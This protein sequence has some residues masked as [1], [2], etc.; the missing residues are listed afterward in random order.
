MRP[1]APFASY[2]NSTVSFRGLSL[3]LSRHGPTLLF[4]AALGVGVLLR[5]IG[6]ADRDLSH[7]EAFTHFFATMPLGELWRDVPK[8]DVHPPLFYALENLIGAESEWRLR[9]PAIIAGALTIPVVFAAGRIA[10]GPKAGAFVGA[11]AAL[12][13]ALSARQ[14]EYAQSARAYAIF[15]LA[16]AVCL[17]GVLL[18]VARRE[19]EE[20]APMNSGDIAGAT[21]VAVGGG[22]M[23]WTHNIAIVYAASIGA[24]GLA[25][26]ATIGGRSLKLL[27]I[28]A[29]AG[30]GA[31]VIWSPAIQYLI[32]QIN[33]VSANYWISRPEPSMIVKIYC[34]TFGL[35][36]GEN[37]PTIEAAVKLVANAALFALGG[38]GLYSMW[39]DGRRAAAVALAFAAFLPAILL[40]I[41]SLLSTPVLLVRVLIPSFV[42]WAV[43]VAYGVVAAPRLKIAAGAFAG[44]VLLAGLP[45]TYLAQ[46]ES[47]R[48]TAQMIA[49]E[50]PGKAIV[51]GFP[52]SASLPF[53]YYAR[54]LSRPPIAAP[55]P[56]PFPA[57]A[58]G[59][60][61]ATGI[62]GE[63][64]LDESGLAM[65]DRTI[66]ANPGADFW[67]TL[68]SYRIYDPKKLLKRHL[69]KRY[70]FIRKDD[71]KAWYVMVLRLVPKE[72]PEAAACMKDD[73]RAVFL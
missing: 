44:L 20:K 16:F 3:L 63:P 59:Y 40:T 61:Y 26:W 38:F 4:A 42:P 56:G 7:D 53:D 39:R 2:W 36:I 46:D 72:S 45:Q 51:F 54:R 47:W 30:A 15:V 64:A 34:S 6:A 49:E 68:R 14:I 29:V 28:F 33:A 18:I 60:F 71:R 37:T 57:V 24:A 58:D 25:L 50:S 41:Y 13:V 52:N 22:L 73:G 35:A 32:N 48:R 10:A 12:L 9:M 11:T 19:T 17:V 65:I 69:E 66:A 27:L 70:C 67:I 21:L 1:N 62:F 8:Y 43:L 5:V 55:V 23:L 31:L